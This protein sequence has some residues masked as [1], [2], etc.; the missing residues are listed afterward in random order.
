M[1]LVI[2]RHKQGIVVTGDTKE[3][4]EILK[5]YNGKWNSKL[6]G[7]VFP[8]RLKDELIQNI[9]ADWR[10]LMEDDSEEEERNKISVSVRSNESSMTTLA[11]KTTL[12]SKVNVI[13]DTED[14]TSEERSYLL[15]IPD[16]FLKK[17][18]TKAPISMGSKFINKNKFIIVSIEKDCIYYIVRKSLKDIYKLYRVY[19]KLGANE[20][21]KRLE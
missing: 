12:P 5:E 11:P 7:W 2:Q 19:N 21:A 20:F 8:I 1:S 13:D 6:Y 10:I 17:L 9:D 15:V 4:K 14:I 16:A 3:Y 18:S